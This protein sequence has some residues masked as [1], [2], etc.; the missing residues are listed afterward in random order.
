[1]TARR[2]GAVRR[3]DR[4]GLGGGVKLT[5]KVGLQGEASYG[6]TGWGGLAAITYDPTADDQYYLGYRLDPDRATLGTSLLYEADLGSFV[7]GAKRRYNDVLSSYAENNYD[8]FGF[9]RSLTSTYGVIFTPNALWTVNGALEYGD[10]AD[11]NGVDLS[12]TAVSL[13]V[14]Y[15]DKEAISWRVK[16]EVRIEDSQD[17]TKD[18]DTYLLSAGFINK[19][20]DDWRLITN[21]DAVISN[22]NQSDILDGKY[23]EA[24]IGFAYRPVDNDRFNMLTKYAYLYDLPGA[25][26]V[27]ANGSVLGPAQKTHIFSADAS[28]DVTERLTIGGKYGFRIGEVS[29]TRGSNNFVFSSAQLGILRADYRIVKK[30]DLLLEGRVL[31]SPSTDTTD[32]GALAAVYYHVGDNFKIGLGYNFGRF[33]DDLRDQTYDDRGIFLNAVGKF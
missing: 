12:R 18:R 27:T 2:S 21:L 13:S 15:K 11:R 30:W 5:E 16:G 33:S 28:Y 24:S 23:V 25:D 1:V 9:K 31:T 3:N 32:Y 17:S 8:M 19:I 14:G 7:L 10:I 4:I 6:T 26:Q 29:T 20:N 22:S